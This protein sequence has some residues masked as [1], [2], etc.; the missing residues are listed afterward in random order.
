LLSVSDFIDPMHSAVFAAMQALHRRG[1]PIELTLLVG[2]LRDAGRFSADMSG[3]QLADLTL[4]FQLY[5][6]PANY[7]HYCRRL[8][9]MSLRRDAYWRGIRLLQEAHTD[10]SGPKVI[11]RAARRAIVRRAQQRRKGDRL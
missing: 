3:V 4:L 5:P 9:T 1:Q 11:Q 10:D 2:E 7:P 8:R 6:V